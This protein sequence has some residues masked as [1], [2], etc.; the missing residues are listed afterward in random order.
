MSLSFF[1]MGV[2]TA[3]DGDI[4]TADVWQ[5]FRPVQ[6]RDQMW[7]SGFHLFPGSRVLQVAADGSIAHQPPI[8]VRMRSLEGLLCHR[9]VQNS[10]LQGSILNIKSK[11]NWIMY[12]IW[13][14][15]PLF[16]LLA[17]QKRNIFN[18]VKSGQSCRTVWTF[19]L[20]V[21][22][23]LNCDCPHE[24]RKCSHSAVKL[25]K[26]TIEVTFEH[27]QGPHLSLEIISSSCSAADDDYDRKTQCYIIF[28]KWWPFN[29]KRSEHSG[30]S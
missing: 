1:C 25:I 13:A 21:C 24:C 28:C 5:R 22:P 27:L 19:D 18:A 10:A 2:E 14:C 15:G 7:T 11:E 26:M 20:R 17:S 23:H 8:S 16:L 12:I 6:H 9:G 29:G 3:R 30:K 4:C